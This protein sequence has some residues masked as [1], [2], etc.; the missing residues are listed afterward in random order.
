MLKRLNTRSVE[1]QQQQQQ[2]AP[3]EDLVSARAKLKSAGPLPP[4]PTFSPSSPRFNDARK[5]LAT[6]SHIATFKTNEH[7]DSFHSFDPREM[8]RYVARINKVMAAASDYSPL[9][10]DDLMKKCGDGKFLCKFMNTVQPGTIDEAIIN[11]S[12]SQGLLKLSQKENGTNPWANTETINIFIN[13]ARGIGIELGSVGSSDFAKA[14][15][16][17]KEHLMLGVIWQ[18][19]RRQ[20]ANEIKEILAQQAAA[21]I[22]PRKQM[23]SEILAE[24][25]DASVT[26]ALQQEEANTAAAIARAVKDPETF[27]CE[28]I[29]SALVAGGVEGLKLGS[30]VSDMSTSNSNSLAL[31]VHALDPTQSSQLALS[32]ED[33]EERAI[34]VIQWA[35]E[36]GIPSLTQAEDLKD[37]NPR[38]IMPFIMGLFTWSHANKPIAGVEVSSATSSSDTNNNLTNVYVVRQHW[39]NPG[40]PANGVKSA[41]SSSTICAFKKEEDALKYV[42]TENL[43]LVGTDAELPHLI[44]MAAEFA[45]VTGYDQQSVIDSLGPIPGVLAKPEDVLE[46]DAL[47][48]RERVET[49][50]QSIS[51]LAYLKAYQENLT[52]VLLS[53]PI[54]KLYA[55][56]NATIF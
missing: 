6:L 24:G 42:L 23:L 47:K 27:L 14:E 41:S 45:R 20:L 16:E 43:A 1:Q 19:L 21:A 55:V 26:A 32:T 22:A 39:A 7:S 11:K 25:D 56:D 48:L 35:S 8:S 40:D 10:T 15:E 28:W 52:N 33:P 17:A 18:L 44:M 13:A 30:V 37:I 31:L 12:L 3:K 4:K 46:D 38:L 2:E 36:H 5:N 53:N 54:Q 50:V 29:S 49:W 34:H 51:G 9:T